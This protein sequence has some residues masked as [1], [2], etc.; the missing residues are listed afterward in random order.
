MDKRAITEIRQLS[1]RLGYRYNEEYVRGVFHTALAVGGVASSVLLIARGT[2]RIKTAADLPRRLVGSG[3]SFTGWVSRVGDGDGLRVRHAPFI[4]LPFRAKHTAAKAKASETVS[5]R[6]AGVDAPECAHFGM[7]G[8]AYGNDAKKWLDQYVRGK[9]VR[10]VVHAVDQYNRALASVFR[11]RGILPFRA[12]NVS[13]ELANAGYA[14][15]YEGS[16]A[17]FGGARRQIE[18]AVARAQRRRRGMWGAKGKLESPSEFKRRL[19]T[20]SR[21][22]P[23]S[24]NVRQQTSAALTKNTPNNASTEDVT[25]KDFIK[26]GGWL[27]K[28]LKK[29]R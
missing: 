29:F 23:A 17:Q 1:N 10:V 24:D 18:K 26:I 4:R 7:P 25:I 3:R 19:K 2:H 14:T 13:V 20:G 16:N 15:V 5:I 22:P 21:S 28:N 9:R 11:P 12:K 27:Y 6:L 8:Q